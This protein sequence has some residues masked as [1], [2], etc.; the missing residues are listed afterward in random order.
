[1]ALV[2]PQ[3][4]EEAFLDLLVNVGYTLRLSRTDVTAGL[5]IAQQNA[6]TTASFTEANFS[7]YSAK[8]L[9]AGSWV[10]TQ[11][12]PSTAVY[13]QQTYTRTVTGA[14]QTIYGYYVTRTSDGV[15]MWFED[16]TGPLTVTANG[17]AIAIT[18]TFTLD[19]DQ[20]ATVTARGIVARQVLTTG[21][22]TYSA[23]ATTDFVL[24]NVDVDSTRTYSIHLSSPGGITATGRWILELWV[25]GVLTSR[26]YDLD[27]GTGAHGYV[28]D[29]STL[30]EPT[31]GS[32]DLE[33]RANEISGSASI[34]FP[35]DAT[36]PREFWVEDI[37]PRLP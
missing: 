23:D 21:S 35:G 30:W 17:D 29:Y 13:A 18:P 7:G 6:L 14:A 25:D 33:I 36:F 37:G 27:F 24:S 28:L 10:T 1:M 2:V 12:D 5:T 9:T 22:A 4:A 32:K 31:T 15:L 34:D 20:E 3:V 19:D 11:A 16:F 8:T 26:V